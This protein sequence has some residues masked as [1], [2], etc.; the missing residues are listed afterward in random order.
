[1]N[2]FY[3]NNKI[4]SL[5]LLGIFYN[6]LHTMHFN[7]MPIDLLLNQDQILS[8]TPSKKENNVIKLDIQNNNLTIDVG[9]INGIKN[10]KE[11]FEFLKSQK[12]NFATMKAEKTNKLIAGKRIRNEAT[13][14]KGGELLKLQSGF[15]IYCKNCLLNSPKIDFSAN[16]ME[17]INSFLI[18]I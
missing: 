9:D 6:S 1:M 10:L 17:F 13:Y 7:N 15:T 8:F 14:L 18:N 5:L 3:T 2:N 12:S 4:I 11:S 16:E